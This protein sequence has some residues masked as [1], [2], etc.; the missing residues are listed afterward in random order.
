MQQRSRW[1]QETNCIGLV[2]T[3]A[4]ERCRFSLH[5]LTALERRPHLMYLQYQSSRIFEGKPDASQFCSMDNPLY[6]QLTSRLLSKEVFSTSTY[7]VNIMSW[8]QELTDVLLFDF[9]PLEDEAAQHPSSKSRSSSL[10]HAIFMRI[11]ALPSSGLGRSGDLLADQVYECTRAISLIYT[12]AMMHFIPLS[13]ACRFLSASLDSPYFLRELRDAVT[14]LARKEAAAW[15]G[16][17]FW[18]CIVAAPMARRPRRQERL[19]NMHDGLTVGSVAD[20]KEMEI[21]R[22]TFLINAIYFWTLNASFDC[23][24]VMRT[25]AR[26]QV[27][28]GSTPFDLP[29]SRYNSKSTDSRSVS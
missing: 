1:W 27:R 8:N 18:I 9:D 3:E 24:V 28:L 19:R 23:V 13:S 14:L 16:V 25:L 15:S 11:N 12:T 21:I 17:L 22:K 4:D 29:R 26:V 20:G 6:P 2:D 5:V 10:A 7:L